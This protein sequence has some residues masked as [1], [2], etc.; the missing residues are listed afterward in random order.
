M[1]R[2]IKFFW[3]NIISYVC[4]IFC[5]IYHLILALI[6][7]EAEALQRSCNCQSGTSGVTTHTAH[8]M[9]N[10]TILISGNIRKAS[11]TL[12]PKVMIY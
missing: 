5:V 1:F 12:D 4:S 3:L 7:E 9:Q 10:M 2:N 6:L 11:Q 8:M